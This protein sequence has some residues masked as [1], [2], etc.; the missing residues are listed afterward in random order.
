MVARQW[1]QPEGRRPT[2]PIRLQIGVEDAAADLEFRA[3]LD[4][5]EYMELDS[6]AMVRTGAR[7]RS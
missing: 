1:V 7:S 4:W 5:A 2:R 3:W 6:L